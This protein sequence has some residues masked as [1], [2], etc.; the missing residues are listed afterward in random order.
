MDQADVS[1]EVG[2]RDLVK[3]T[4]SRQSSKGGSLAKRDG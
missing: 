2:V 1:T 4:S 3:E